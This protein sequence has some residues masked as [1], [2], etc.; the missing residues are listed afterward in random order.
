MA[1]PQ[2]HG[3]IHP[4]ER[5]TDDAAPILGCSLEL[6]LNED[7]RSRYQET[8]RANM[9]D[10]AR[11]DYRCRIQRI[12]KFWE[13]ECAEYYRIGTCSL[14][15]GELQDESKFHFNRYKY[16]LVYKGLNVKYV[17]HFLMSTKT[18]TNGKIKGHQDVR[19]YKDAIMWGANVAGERLPVSFY[20]E[21]DMYLASY[22]KLFIK[23]KKEGEVD[24]KEA[25]PIP[26]SLYQMILR[27]SIEENNIFC[28]FWSLAQ[29]NCIG[30][31]S[32]IDPLAFHNFKIG[33]DSII[34]KYDDSKA[35]KSGDRLSEK[36]IYA[37]PFEWTQ[38]F[39][40]GMGVYCALE[41]QRLAEHERLFLTPGVNEGAASMRYSEQL[42]TIVARHADEVMN[43]MRPEHFTPYGLR[44]GSATHAV[45]GTTVTPSLPS[46]A[47]RGEWSQGAV[48]DVYWHFAS[49]GDHYLGRILACLPSHDKRFATL[50][51][52]WNT[53]QP[54][55]NPH[56]SRAM[57]ILYGPLM[58]RYRGKNNDPTP[59][60]L[61]CLACLVHHADSLLDVMLT[62][63]GH[64]MAK[65]T[66]LHDVD[67]IGFLKPLVTLDPTPMVMTTP[68][69]VPPHIELA[70]MMSQV[71]DLTTELMSSLR[72]QTGEL[73]ANVQKAIEEK[74]WESG[75]ITGSRLKEM[76]EK[77][78]GDQLTKI[79]SRLLD[80][81]NQFAEALRGTGTSAR[82]IGDQDCDDRREGHEVVATT[83]MYRGRVYGVPQDFEFPRCLTL[84]AALH[85]WLCGM[86][87]CKDGL[88]RVRP[89]VNLSLCD[90][91]DELKSSFKLNWKGIFDFVHD[92]A[93]AQVDFQALELPN[94]RDQEVQS[95]YARCVDCL[96]R[97]VSYCFQNTKGRDPLVRWSIATWS[98][99]TRHSSIR[100]LGTESDKA[101]LSE[102]TK[103]NQ[104]RPFKERKRPMCA[105]PKYLARQIRH[106]ERQH[107]TAAIRH[108]EETRQ[109]IAPNRDE[110]HRQ[111]IAEASTGL[112]LEDSQ[113][114]RQ[115]RTDE[116][117]RVYG[118]C[119][120]AG[121]VFPQFELNHH[122]TTCGNGVHNL[123]AQ[124][125]MLF[126]EENEL[127]MYCSALC[128]NRHTY[129]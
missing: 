15:E 89:F 35:D 116:R 90:L 54:L 108:H 57:T 9:D 83:F 114:R 96:H 115:E 97:R 128:K 71:L 72:L 29:W 80:M 87:V 106:R 47:R 43:Q 104:S 112:A 5:D 44:K 16:D 66:L 12:V 73:I 119:Y 79:D 61:R 27:W 65:L 105:R 127:V 94:T 63:P 58:V 102:G 86:S 20:K 30:R 85:F 118:N 64:D 34:C 50:P 51:P 11:K 103:R 17:L 129:S 41:C 23:A 45:S 28:W 39:W 53:A 76:L 2:R 55:S 36:N 92:D 67:L 31:C 49:I 1:P 46:V 84:E 107:E 75:H 10:K 24:E 81:Q 48:L 74:A 3:R 98:L 78:Q 62:S 4:H 100:K 37:N 22:K 56:I 91:P 60:L 82:V 120:I 109:D 40:T 93:I 33:Q 42:Q 8:I 25:D 69:G 68:T 95:A 88:Q 21:M 70:S 14:S 38:C 125:S 121:C 7:F 101:L 13:T 26:V 19:K 18:K 32:S 59:M 113:P 110:M 52:H 122:C 126:D 99:R 77:F 117:G 6:D 124:Q 123:C 111:E